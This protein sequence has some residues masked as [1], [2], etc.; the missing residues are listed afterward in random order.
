MGV[1]V[2]SVFEI[3]RVGSVKNGLVET[4]RRLPG[5]GVGAADSG[6]R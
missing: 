6:D 5:T 1:R 3:E 4:V 2:A